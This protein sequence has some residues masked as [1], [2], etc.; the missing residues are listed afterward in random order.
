MFIIQKVSEWVENH[1]DK[2]ELFYLPSYVPEYNPD[3][4]VNSDLKRSVGQKIS[5][6]S[7][8]EL[9]SNI[10]VHLKS[11]QNNPSKVV[12]FFNAPYTKY[13]A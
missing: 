8:D 6:K 12:S 4:L 13:A 3:D 9:E 7:A 5:P 10:H 11:L 1:K 2:I